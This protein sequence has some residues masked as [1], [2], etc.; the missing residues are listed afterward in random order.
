VNVEKKKPRYID[1]GHNIPYPPSMASPIPVAV[2]VNPGEQ[3]LESGEQDH[4]SPPNEMT[5][6]TTKT[7][8]KSSTV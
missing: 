3:P 1:L 5:P 2:I 4:L 8:S 7:I 6:P